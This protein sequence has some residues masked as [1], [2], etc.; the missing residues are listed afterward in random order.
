MRKQLAD[1][2]LGKSSDD[3]PAECKAE[4]CNQIVLVVRA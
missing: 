2:L 4:P 1:E 3:E